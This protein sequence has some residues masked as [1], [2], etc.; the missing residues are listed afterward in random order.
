[1]IIWL[2]ECKGVLYKIIIWTYFYFSGIFVH[3]QNN[4]ILGAAFS[5]NVAANQYYPFV[6]SLAQGGIDTNDLSF[7]VTGAGKLIII[8]NTNITYII[9]L[10]KLHHFGNFKRS[11]TDL[12]HSI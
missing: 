1:M 5:A 2:Y 8:S 6:F 7:T 3:A 9:V 4:L 10:I 12:E 11:S